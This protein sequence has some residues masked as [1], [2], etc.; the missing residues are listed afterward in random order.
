M[1]HAFN[2][3]TSDEEGQVQRTKSASAVLDAKRFS[4]GVRCAH[5]H[6][7]DLNSSLLYACPSGIIHM[8][9]TWP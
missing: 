9:A 7:K 8:F 4:T 3:L 6:G 5:M 1:S 2:P